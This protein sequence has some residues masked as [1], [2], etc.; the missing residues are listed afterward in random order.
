MSDHAAEFV[1]PRRMA[2]YAPI[3]SA[4]VAAILTFTPWHLAP[5][6]ALPFL[7]YAVFGGLS[8]RR[9]NKRLGTIALAIAGIITTLW[10]LT[11]G[12]VYT[13]MK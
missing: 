11:F 13:T 6:M 2:S 4:A 9:R 7:L 8:E 12:L 3:A 10:V 5:L 1:S